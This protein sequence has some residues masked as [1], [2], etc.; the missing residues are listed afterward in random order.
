[1]SEEYNFVVTWRCRNCGYKQ[2]KKYKYGEGV[3][4]GS[5]YCEKCPHCGIFNF[6][7]TEDRSPIF[8]ESKT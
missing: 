5:Q 7:P 4:V 1:M 3:K 2:F 8:S 6:E